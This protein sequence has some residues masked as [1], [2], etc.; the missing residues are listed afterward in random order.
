M[1]VFYMCQCIFDM[2]YGG[3]IGTKLWDIIVDLCKVE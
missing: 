2:M 3:I 1:G